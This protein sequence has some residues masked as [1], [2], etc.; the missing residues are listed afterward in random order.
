MLSKL[1]SGR[2]LFTIIAALV[3]AVMSVSGQ[4]PSDKV[5]EIILVVVYAYFSKADKKDDTRG[6]K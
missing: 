4:L 6:T 3:F 2:F 5:F 1:T